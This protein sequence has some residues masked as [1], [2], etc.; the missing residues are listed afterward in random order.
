MLV[1]DAEGLVLLGDLDIG[2]SPDFLILNQDP[3][4]D[5]TVLLNT[6]KHVVFAFHGGA[7]VTNQLRLLKETGQPKKKPRW[8]AYTPP[9]RSLPLTYR[10][11]K[12]WNNWDTEHF[13][14]MFFGAL[15]L[16]RQYWLSQDE[17]S[18][19]QVG[20]LESYG[21]GEIR[22]TRFGVVGAL[23]FKRPWIYSVFAGSE[24][25]DRGFDAKQGNSLV[26]Y[27]LRLDIPLT[28]SMSLAVGKV[29]EPISMERLMPLAYMPM[30]ERSTLMDALFRARSVGVV[31]IG[32]GVDRRLTWA[33]GVFN[34]W[35]D[36]GKSFGASSSQLVGRTTWLPFL[37][38]DEG[39][40]VHLGLG[41]RY[42]NGNGGLRYR[43]VP[44]FN[45]SP[46]FVD[47]DFLLTDYAMTYNPEASWRIGPLWLLGEAAISKVNL[48]G[49]DQ[50]VFHGYY[51]S[52][53]WSLSG[54]I[55]P[56]NRTS[57]VFGPLPVAKPVTRGGGALGSWVCGGQTW[58]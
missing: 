46:I 36:G 22:G 57:D 44:E 41:V 9:P 56:Y 13:S 1:L 54:E 20:D 8:F 34:D 15:V 43:T 58:T 40:V 53:S 33:G 11:S 31:L 3:R 38:K 26:L 32:T 14:G 23:K 51:V 48:T 21:A 4:Q 52:G 42:T 24:A 35:F 7:I 10:D 27:D 18:E 50:A 49:S 2:D 45:L 19:K 5:F 6:K 47:T 37:A 55:R 28:N 39:N 30:Q 16:D 17:A 12:K 29:K 25:F